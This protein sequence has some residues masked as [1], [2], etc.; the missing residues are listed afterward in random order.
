MW[1]HGELGDCG[2]SVCGMYSGQR[3]GTY[4]GEP[5][6]ET[7]CLAAELEWLPQGLESAVPARD[8]LRD[9]QTVSHHRACMRESPW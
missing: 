1:M 4:M 7:D 9:K 5:P 6:L 3:G 8:E 2:I